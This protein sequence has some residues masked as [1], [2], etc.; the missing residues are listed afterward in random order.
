MENDIFARVLDIFKKKESFFLV[1]HYLPDGDSI[2]SLV[3]LANALLNKGKKITVFCRDEVP[4]IYKFLNEPAII[5]NDFDAET[6]EGNTLIVLDCSDTS[7]TGISLEQLSKFEE[8]VN[9]DHHVTNEYFGDV[10]LVDPG[11][12]ATGEIIYELINRGNIDLDVKVAQ[13]LY[14]AIST[15]TGSFKYENSTP[16]AHQVVADLMV[17]HKLNPSLISQKIFDEKPL[18]YFLLLNKALSSLE[19]F[20]DGK[21]ACM[22]LS[23][24][25]LFEVGTTLE[26]IDGIVNYAKSIDTVEIGILFY[27]NGKGEVKVGLRSKEVDVSQIAANFNGGGHKKAAG[28]RSEDIYSHTKK[29]TLEAAASLIS[30]H[31]QKAHASDFK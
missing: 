10:N 17:N 19:L 12:S 11:A 4:A 15:D 7:R 8:I 26:T 18:A 25:Y 5:S 28:F 1:S 14:V 27:V 29:K 3:A 31:Y 24:E 2:G 21:I 13:A 23:E 20:G 22:T 30:N 9:I 16:R 6:T